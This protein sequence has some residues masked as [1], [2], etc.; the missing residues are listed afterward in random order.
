METWWI[1]QEGAVEGAYWHEGTG[2]RQYQLSPPGSAVPGG[3]TSLSRKANTMEVWWIGPG[4]SVE[5][6]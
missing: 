5:N 1:T 2:W 6:A 4:G 3:I